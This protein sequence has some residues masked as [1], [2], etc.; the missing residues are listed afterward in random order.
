VIFVDTNIVIDLLGAEPAI[1]SGWS[2]RTYARALA[3]DRLCCNHV[4]L[5]EVAAG[6]VR[7]DET[8][9]DLDRLRIEVLDLSAAAALSAGKAFAAYRRRGGRRETILPDF[10]VGGHAAV[11]GA[12]LMTRDR[13]LASY[14][15]DL[16]LITP[17]TQP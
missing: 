5:A 8:I 16:S 1:L 6:A 4:V 17:E 7:P 12:A 13:R 15:P 2:G 3:T 11:L 14:F 9:G 10:L